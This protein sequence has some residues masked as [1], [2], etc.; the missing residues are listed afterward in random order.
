MAYKKLVSYL[1]SEACSHTYTTARL[2]GGIRIATMRTPRRQRRSSLRCVT[3]QNASASCC[4]G[5][6][7]GVQVNDAYKALV[8]ECKKRNKR[9]K[10]HKDEDGSSSRRPFWAGSTPS[11]SSTTTSSSTPSAASSSGATSG[12]SSSRSSCAAEKPTTELPEKTTAKPHD[13]KP[14]KNAD[15]HS[16]K[17][18][19][20]SRPSEKPSSKH[21]SSD[22][23]K[24]DASATKTRRSGDRDTPSHTSSSKHERSHPKSSSSP[25]SAAHKSP[26]PF[27]PSNLHADSDSDTASECEYVRYLCYY[28]RSHTHPDQ[29]VNS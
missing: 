2:C 5:L 13:P 29:Q 21:R 16:E 9:K 7:S 28:D 23:S 14:S 11:T 3:I 19:G 25:S 6:T 18:S 8:E 4:L 12:A 24:R 10:S 27:K 22:S 1:Y 20:S 15:T 26:R 17:S